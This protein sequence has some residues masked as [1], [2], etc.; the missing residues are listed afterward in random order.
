MCATDGAGR[1]KQAYSCYHTRMCATELNQ[2]ELQTAVHAALSAWG[3]AEGDP[4]NRLDYLILVQ[5]RRATMPGDLPATLRLATND[6]LHTCLQELAQQDPDSAN[7]L[8]WRFLDGEIVQQVAN[9]LHLGEHQ[10]KRRQSRAIQ[11]LAV[12]L[13]QKEMAV[14]AARAHQLEALLLPPSYHTLFGVDEPLTRLVELL[15]TPESPWLIAITGMGGIG[16]TSLTN[17]AARQVIP[18]FCYHK[19]VWL[20][21]ADAEQSD[22]PLT[23]AW[24]LR[25]LAAAVCP[26]LPAAIPA[27]ERDVQLRQTLKLFPSLVILDNLE[28]EMAA[29]LLAT[30]HDLSRPSKFVVTNRVRP[31]G[32]AGI[33]LF[34]L[35]ELSPAAA[36]A[37]LRDQARQIGAQALAAA[38][39]AEL[40]AI[41]TQT[42]GNPLALK[43]IAG[44]SQDFSLPHILADLT[45]VQMSA[46]DELY[47]YIYWKSWNTLSQPAR[48][49]LEIMP[50]VADSGATPDQLQATSN[51][52]PIHLMPAIQELIHRSLLEV[53]GSLNERRYAIHSLTRTFLLREISHWP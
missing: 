24:L 11:S 41:Y 37:L 4:Q 15:H 43:L 17:A 6:V 35:P 2:E 1:I 23:A 22:A 53:R 9:R 52:E 10:L 45:Q 39:E 19:I 18:H 50:L 3:K 14:R 30:L 46:T 20:T 26:L 13:W 21:V 34:P 16:K 42:G 48:M 29:D 47:R 12:I 28:S 44:L 27:G 38:T 5:E 36:T 7:I 51:L 8:T 49:L 33:Y 40:N 25:R 31:S 32:Q